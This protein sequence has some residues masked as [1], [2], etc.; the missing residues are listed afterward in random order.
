MIDRAFGK[1]RQFARIESGVVLVEALIAIPAMTFF[2]IGIL[3]FGNMM[4]QRQQLQVG[5]RDA[6]RYWSRCRPGSGA[7]DAGGN[8]LADYMPCSITIAEQIA[9]F[10]YPGASA[11]TSSRRVPTWDD[12]TELTITPATPPTNPTATDVVTVTGT[13]PYSGSPVLSW[14]LNQPPTIEYSVEMRYIGW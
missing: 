13:A 2:T 5:V 9:F 8:P 14:I 10:G 11:S 6:A 7:T 1:A 3:E 4:W 12:S